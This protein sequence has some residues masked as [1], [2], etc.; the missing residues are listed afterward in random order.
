MISGK[1]KE[2]EN[3]ICFWAYDR[4]KKEQGF[5]R[6]ILYGREGRE[7]GSFVTAHEG[8]E[9]YEEIAD[10]IGEDELRFSEMENR[11]MYKRKYTRK[12]ERR[13]YD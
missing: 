2:Q 6:H 11:F 7:L 12:K 4:S 13:N 1:R 8:R 9:P 5:Y 10:L 3:A